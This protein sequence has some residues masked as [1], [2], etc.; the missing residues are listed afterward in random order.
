MSKTLSFSSAFGL[1]FGLRELLFVGLCLS[2]GLGIRRISL[3]FLL[4][5]LEG[6]ELIFCEMSETTPGLEF[7][8]ILRP[9]FTHG[10]CQ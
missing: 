8:A 1:S 7:A 3:L 6:V 5:N 2:F 4:L 9:C 10:G